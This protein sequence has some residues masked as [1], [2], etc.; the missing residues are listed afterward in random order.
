MTNAER[1]RRYRDRMTD[2]EYDKQ[3]EEQRLRMAKFRGQEL[4]E[5]KEARIEEEFLSKEQQLLNTFIS[6]TPV[7]KEICMF[8]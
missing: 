3:K 8:F 6:S 2:E 1:K 4:D 5:E 7:W